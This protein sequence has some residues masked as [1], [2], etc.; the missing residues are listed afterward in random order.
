MNIDIFYHKIKLLLLEY[1]NTQKLDKDY[2]EIFLKEFNNNLNLKDENFINENK[3]QLFDKLGE[4]E[5]NIIKHS[6]S[7][8]KL[9][10]KLAKKLHPDLNKNASDDFIKMSKAY[11]KNDYITL[12]LL[13]YENNIKNEL[14]EDE[15]ALI[16]NSI[17]DKENE[18][19]QIKNGL[20]W[21]WI[22]ADNEI[23]KEN[24]K[25]YIINNN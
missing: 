6:L 13:S 17:I 15:I 18:I 1:E 22:L 24:I 4:K 19:N 7:C 3:E 21:K 9:Y 25:Q 23:E 11:E 12:F 14:T 16:N 20:H 5:I 10:R 8:I 2:M